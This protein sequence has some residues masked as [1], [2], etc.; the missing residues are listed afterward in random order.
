VK[1]LPIL[2][3]IENFSNEEFRYSPLI[4]SIHSPPNV[5]KK[6]STSISHTLL[7][8]YK[9]IDICVFTVA[10]DIL[11][12][13]EIIGRRWDVREGLDGQNV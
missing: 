3:R 11:N 5:A 12:A 7:H 9:Y 1:L 2:E 8:L 13:G 6:I 4:S 10:N